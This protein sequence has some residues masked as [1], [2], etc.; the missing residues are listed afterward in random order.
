MLISSVTLAV[1]ALTCRRGVTAA[2][3]AVLATGIVL[4]VSTAA[5]AFGTKVQELLGTVIP[6]ILGAGP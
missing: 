6:Y 3:Y 1:R 4:T 5:A 2:E